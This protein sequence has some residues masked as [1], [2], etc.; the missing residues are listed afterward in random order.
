MLGIEGS[1]SLSRRLGQ[2]PSRDSGAG[3]CGYRA[4]EGGPGTYGSRVKSRLG[5]AFAEEADNVRPVRVLI[6]SI[7]DGQAGRVDG[8]THPI[9]SCASPSRVKG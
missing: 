7:E 3:P 1:Q 8:E 5:H 4:A 6:A 2:T 9:G